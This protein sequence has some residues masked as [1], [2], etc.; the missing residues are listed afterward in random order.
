[1]K[2]GNRGNGS[3]TGLVVVAAVGA[4]VGAGVALLFAP[5]S[6]TETRKWLASNTRGMKDKAMTAFDKVRETARQETKGVIG[7]AVKEMA[8]VHTVV[9]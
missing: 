6:G 1:M 2:E 7:Q 5:R 4:A 3:W 8:S 9:R